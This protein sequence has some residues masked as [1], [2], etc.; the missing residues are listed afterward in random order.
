MELLLPDIPQV[1]R[2]PLD[3]ASVS[4]TDQASWAR[5][6]AVRASGARTERNF[7]SRRGVDPDFG[8]IDTRLDRPVEPLSAEFAV[9]TVMLEP[10]VHAAVG[11]PRE[12]D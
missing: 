10:V 1:K 12:C 7:W 2:L 11:S 9:G 8:L 3:F 6:A 5:S 4:H